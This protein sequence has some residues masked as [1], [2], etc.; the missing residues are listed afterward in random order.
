MFGHVFHTSNNSLAF[1][2]FRIQNVTYILDSYEQYPI[3]NLHSALGIYESLYILL[4]VSLAVH[5]W[6]CSKN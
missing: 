5:F 1:P 4:C 2:F 3:D 6:I